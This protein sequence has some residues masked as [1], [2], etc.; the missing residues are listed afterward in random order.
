VRIMCNIKDSICWLLMQED[1]ASE[2]EKLKQ[3]M[4]EQGAV[5]SSVYFAHQGNPGSG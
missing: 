3:F 1:L 2:E 5:V 4:C